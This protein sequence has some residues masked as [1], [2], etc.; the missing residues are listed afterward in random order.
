MRSFSEKPRYAA[1]NISL[2]AIT[3]FNT[4]RSNAL[5][6]PL[7]V[8]VLYLNDLTKTTTATTVR[9]KSS[10]N[11]ALKDINLAITALTRRFL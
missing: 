1:F 7:I 2:L 4:L 9:K 6:P 8:T 3:F 5:S 11:G 10:I